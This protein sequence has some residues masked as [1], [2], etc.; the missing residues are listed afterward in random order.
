VR[1]EVSQPCKTTVTTIVMYIL[2]FI[3]PGVYLHGIEENQNFQKGKPR[4]DLEKLLAQ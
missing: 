3:M 4:L 1:A 2:F